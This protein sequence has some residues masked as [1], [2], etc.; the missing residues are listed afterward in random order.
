M[1]DHLSFDSKLKVISES[2]KGALNIEILKL[3]S[4]V[5]LGTRK[6]TLMTL[7]SYKKTNEMFKSELSQLQ[8]V[9][10]KSQKDKKLKAKISFK[11]KEH[12]NFITHIKEMGLEKKIL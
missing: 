7:M 9:F 1:A 2:D 4:L 10:R 12:H 8:K 6:R 3:N 11:T 5:I